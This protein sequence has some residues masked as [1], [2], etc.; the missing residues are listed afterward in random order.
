MC[1]EKRPDCT[2]GCIPSKCKKTASGIFF[3]NSVSNFPDCPPV[4]S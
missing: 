4:N 3:L 1:Q 2:S